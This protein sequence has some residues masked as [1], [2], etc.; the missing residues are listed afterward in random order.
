[1]SQQWTQLPQVVTR[2]FETTIAFLDGLEVANPRRAHAF[3]DS[4]M[5]AEAFLRS[6]LAAHPRRRG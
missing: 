6:P 4:R 1:M 5:L 3:A 2:C